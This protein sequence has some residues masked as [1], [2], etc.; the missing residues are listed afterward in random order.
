[1]TALLV[2]L[3]DAVTERINSEDWSLDFLAKRSYADWELKLDQATELLVDV[4]PV[5]RKK[6]PIENRSLRDHQAVVHV[7]IR[8]KFP[9]ETQD[10]AT[11][12]VEAAEVDTLIELAEDLETHFDHE[13][14][15]SRLPEAALVSS[16]LL[17]DYDRDL[18]YENRQFVSVLELTFRF[19]TEVS[20][21]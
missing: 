20:L 19:E 16:R 6:L 21:A 4:V 7:G 13:D 2:Q 3:A 14:R 1:M 9:A 10:M 18:L 15:L 11:G 8:K 12:R 5:S 17:G